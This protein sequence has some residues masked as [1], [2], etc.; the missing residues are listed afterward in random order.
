MDDKNLSLVIIRDVTERRR[1]DESLLA[2][3]KK[4]KDALA[5]IKQLRGLVPVCSMCKKIRDD[6]GY[7]DRIESYVQKYSEAESSH[8]FC[9]DCAE[10]L[11]KDCDSLS[12]HSGEY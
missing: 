9:P 5:E 8:A 6:K 1:I 2:E 4:L 7:W 12:D 11:Y 10:D 3:K